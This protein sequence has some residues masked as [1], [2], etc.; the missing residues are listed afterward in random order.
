M[1]LILIANDYHPRYK[2]VVAGNRDEYYSRPTFPAT[3]WPE[4]PA[5]LAGKDLIKGGTW[6]GITTKGRFAAVTVYREPFQYPPHLMSRGLL[7]ANFLN[8]NDPAEVYMENL[9]T[10]G[11]EFKGYSLLAGTIDSLY[12]LSN[13]ENIIHR[14]DKGLHGLSNNLLDVRWPKVSKGL[15]AFSGC[16]QQDEVKAEHLFEI[17]ADREQPADEDLPDT[18]VGLERE[19]MLGSVCIVSPNY[20]TRATTVILVDRKNQVQFWERSLAS[21]QSGIWNEVHFEFQF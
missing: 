9:V 7:A 10:K 20:G 12:Y 19:R 8:G 16:L 1:C 21:V 17:M 15:E 3:Y 18:G 2:L 6:T 13:R 4:N 14:L 5:V 11:E